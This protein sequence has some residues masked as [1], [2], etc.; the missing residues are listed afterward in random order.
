M[1][2]PSPSEFRE[3]AL[4]LVRSGRTV[5]EVAHAWGV[6][7]SLARACLMRRSARRENCSCRFRKN[8]HVARQ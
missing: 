5:V 4:E 7:A 2:R 3:G 8:R 6:N 1:P